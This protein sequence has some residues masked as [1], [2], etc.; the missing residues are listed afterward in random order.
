LEPYT[1][2]DL[3][4]ERGEEDL[5]PSI[6]VAP[7]ADCHD[8]DDQN[9]I[10]HLVHDS[11]VSNPDAIEIIDTTKLLAAGGTGI[12]CKAIQATP[13]AGSD[14]GRQFSKRAF[15]GG[16]EANLVGHAR[17]AS[18]AEFGLELFPGG[19]ALFLEGPLCSLKIDSILERANQ[20][21]VFHGNDRGEIAS[22]SGEDDSLAAID[23][24]VQRIRELLSGLAR[25][26]SG[27]G[28]IVRQVPT[29]RNVR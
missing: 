8:Q 5:E 29:V 27:H 23:D 24:S 11:V 4:L 18:K 3:V 14:L 28:C 1:A 21:E 10:R 19:A 22:P 15:R 6:H 16:L 12:A 26:K 20:F 9:L 7:M 2:L 13:E 25:A 17:A